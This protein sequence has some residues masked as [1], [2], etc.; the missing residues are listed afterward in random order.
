M[1]SIFLTLYSGDRGSYH[2]AYKFRERI[3]QHNELKGGS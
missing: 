1:I 3:E 2:D